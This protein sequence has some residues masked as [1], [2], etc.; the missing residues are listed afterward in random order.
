MHFTTPVRLLFGTAALSL[1]LALTACGTTG[2]GGTGTGSESTTPTFPKDHDAAALVPEAL[3]QAGVLRIA[4]PTNEPPTQFFREGTKE[5]TG[6]NPDIAH[7]V[8]G[9]LGLK[10]DIVVS[11]FDSIIP[12]LEADRFDMTV[13]SMTPTK[14]RMASL[15]FVEY[16]QMGS[17]LAVAAGNP[18]HLGFD[19]LCGKRVAVLTGSYQLTVNIPPMNE[20]CTAASRAPLEVQQFQDT[21]QAISSLVSDRT[22]AVYADGPILAYAAKQNPDIE[23]AGENDVAPVAIGIPRESGLLDPVKAAMA[24]ILPSAEYQ[25]VLASYGVESMAITEARVNIPQ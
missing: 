6:I 20:A 9:A 10:A 2:A 16:V 4:I 1:S 17:G 14:E 25:K 7:L 8:A 18:Q 23:I 12:G 22:D 11:N 3:A 13:S 15:D 21:R 19:Q 5:M 24:V